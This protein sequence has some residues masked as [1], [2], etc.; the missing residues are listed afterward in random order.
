VKIVWL[1]KDYQNLVGDYNELRLEHEKLKLEADRAA[2]SITAL[3]TDN[4]KLSAAIMELQQHIRSNPS[5]VQN[6]MDLLQKYQEQVLQEVPLAPGD[7]PAWLTP[8]D[9]IPDERES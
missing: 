7:D 9:D 2:D 6:V 3:R 5:Y 1:F 4:E 8:G